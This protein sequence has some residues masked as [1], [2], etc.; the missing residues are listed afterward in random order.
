ML[1]NKAEVKRAIL[2]Y[3]YLENLQKSEICK[4]IIILRSSCVLK[5]FNF[6]STY[7]HERNESEQFYHTSKLN[8][9]DIS[10]LCYC[11]GLIQQDNVPDIIL[12]FVFS[13]GQ[14]QK[15]NCTYLHNYVN[16]NNL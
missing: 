14:E 1:T 11:S 9:I 12:M 6:H 5:V 16:I 8:K 13:I 7:L 2:D 15:D 10:N 3:I 4:Y